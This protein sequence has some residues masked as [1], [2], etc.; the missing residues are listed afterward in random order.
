MSGTSG[1]RD[2]SLNVM[3]PL[4]PF[5]SGTGECQPGEGHPG[6]GKPWGAP[7]KISVAKE[8][9]ARAA[10]LLELMQKA[11]LDG[12]LTQSGL[13]ELESLQRFY[14]ALRVQVEKGA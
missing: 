5:E 14:S 4:F 9:L 11:Q 12:Q 2:V 7:D 6:D 1:A 3:I 13:C 8:I 10:A